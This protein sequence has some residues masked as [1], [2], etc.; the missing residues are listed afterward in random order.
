MYLENAISTHNKFW[1]YLIGSI[2]IVFA[3]FIGQIPLGIAIVLKSIESKQ[4]F[5][6]DETKL[7]KMLSGNLSL[8]L[9]LFSFVV[10]KS[11]NRVQKIINEI[12]V[13]SEK[14][15][16]ASDNRL[17]I[18]KSA[19]KITERNLLLGVG[20]GDVRSELMK[21]YKQIGNQEIIKK[22]YNVH[23]QF[24]EVLLENGLI[25]LV[26]FLV[27]LGYMLFIAMRYNNVLYFLFLITSIIFFLFETV[28]YRFPG[29]SFFALFSFLMIYIPKKHQY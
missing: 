13:G 27:I 17:I 16:A 20:I 21:E 10:L 2:I 23:N 25:G 14:L 7:M 29:M 5:P 11:N 19:L 1:K 26:I 24:L 8:F 6:T 28:L 9:I 18:W 15:N 12:T 22:N 4:G 3:S